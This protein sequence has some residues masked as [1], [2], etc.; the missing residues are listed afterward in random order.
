MA[1]HAGNTLPDKLV[2][3]VVPVLVAGWVVMLL[4]L[5]HRVNTGIPAFSPSTLTGVVVP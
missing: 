2:A 4:L 5:S 1:S 3:L